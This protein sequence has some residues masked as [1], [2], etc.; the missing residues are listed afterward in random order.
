MCLFVC[1]F[2]CLFAIVLVFMH[3]LLLLFVCCGY[4]STIYVLPFSD[5]PRQRSYLPIR[6]RGIV[7]FLFCAAMLREGRGKGA[8]SP[9]R[10]HDPRY[11]NNYSYS[12]NCF[13]ESYCNIYIYIYINKAKSCVPCGDKVGQ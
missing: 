6:V 2:V 5:A 12:I 4:I 10:D 1:L 13:S 3:L 11:S 7:M 8:H 9:D